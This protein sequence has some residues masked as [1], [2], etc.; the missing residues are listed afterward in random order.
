MMKVWN[1]PVVEELEVKATAYNPEGG[2]K[3][4]G[5]YV[6]VD[7]KYSQY[8]YGPSSGNTGVPGTTV[9]PE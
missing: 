3:V 7:G 4:D 8:T 5:Q 6:S 1:N 2:T 9:K